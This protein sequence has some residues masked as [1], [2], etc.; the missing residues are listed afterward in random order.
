MLYQS[1]KLFER[2]IFGN[3]ISNAKDTERFYEYLNI[4]DRTVGRA[5]KILEE[6]KSYPTAPQNNQSKTHQDEQE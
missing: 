1:R 5:I 2:N 6:G 3:I 4:D